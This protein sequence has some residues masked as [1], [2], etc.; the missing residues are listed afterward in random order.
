M[1]RARLFYFSCIILRCTLTC[2]N[3]FISGKIKGNLI[4]DGTLTID[5]CGRITGDIT[6]R[7]LVVKEGGAL[8]GKCT[9][10]ISRDV[11]V[12]LDL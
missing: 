11:S 9:M 1:V 8:D 12:V 4:C 10:I 2:K 5:Y 7:N 6:A 3:A